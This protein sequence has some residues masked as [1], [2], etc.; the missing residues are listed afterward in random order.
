[1]R[2]GI[3]GDPVAGS[4]SP[5]IFKAAY[6]GKYAYDLIEEADFDLSWKKF[7]D[8]Y[9]GINVTAPFKEK[10]FA[11]AD[12]L[13]EEVRMTGAANLIVKTEKGTEAH[14]TDFNGIILCCTETLGASEDGIADMYPDRPCALIVGCGGAGRA[15]A[16]AAKKMGYSVSLMNR[17][18]A[19]AEAIASSLPEED[20]TVEPI[21]NFREA[22]RRC[23]L[24]IY[25]VPTAIGE[26]DGLSAED[27]AEKSGRPP[28]LLLEANYKTPAF[29]GKLSGMPR[30]PGC[31]YISGKLWLLYQAVAGYDIFTGESPDFE[32][33]RNILF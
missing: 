25:T 6:N 17:T 27:F 31:R 29:P 23:D 7:E 9:H 5:Q 21:E 2:F 13:S 3:I 4:L 12:I 22:L 15:A 18:I 16:A 10:A 28:K 11:R 8:S 19:K 26:L 14:N 1:M 20:F 33:M 24:V 32:A 30:L